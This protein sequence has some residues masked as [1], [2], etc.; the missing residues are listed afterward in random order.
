MKLPDAPWRRRS[1]MQ[2]LLTALDSA[3][4]QTRF[5][6]G[7]IRD[8]LLGLPVSDV[9]LATR[10]QPNDVIDRL[11]KVRIRAVP[12]GLAHGTVTA[13]LRDG[14]VEVTTLRRDV[15]TDGRRATIAYTEDWQEDA[16]RRDFTIN[17]ISAD[18]QT[19]EMFDY[20]GGIADLEARKVRFIG[21]PLTRIAED[22]LRILR[23]FRFHARFG[24]G[25]PDADALD[26]CTRRANDLMAL[27]RE[28]I[29]DELFKLLGLPDPAPTVALMVERGILAPVL[30]EIRPEAVPRLARLVVQEAA[31]GEAPEPL[32]RLAALLPADPELA[33]SIAARL[34]LSKKAAKRLASAAA[35]EPGDADQPR[36][37][38]YR[39]GIEEAIDRLLLASEE[40][41]AAAAR[42]RPLRSWEKPRFPLG[43]G[44][45]MAMGLLPGPVIAR[46]LQAI[47][48]E[49][50]AQGFPT[51]P[52]EV[53]ALARS[54][55]DQA[56]RES[57]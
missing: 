40:P 16:A 28:R 49:W 27:S 21:D 51:E 43:G 2:Q 6:G 1:G 47:E 11:K 41:Q 5:V 37:L 19:S 22:H 24:K 13:V 4:G 7:S 54:H 38:A 26:A 42:V 8:T 50:M 12:T 18:P 9:D 17:A 29:A 15:S 35:V 33:A 56:L 55:V 36:H 20:F 48:R 52:E 10:L 45:I 3:Q 25:R 39:I 57:Q 31:A 44:D 34:R 30:P 46:T 23:F 32:R 53:R 14:P